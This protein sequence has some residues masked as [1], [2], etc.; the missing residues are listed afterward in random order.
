MIDVKRAVQKVWLY[1]F[2][3][4]YS[5]ETLKHYFD[6]EWFDDEYI[7]SEKRKKNEVS[8]STKSKFQPYRCPKCKRAWR[9]YTLPKGKI[10]M[11]EFIGKRVPMESLPCPNELPCKDRK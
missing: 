11:R 3:S 1:I 6:E 4:V 10:P 9:Y 8:Y 7:E 2:E 5:K